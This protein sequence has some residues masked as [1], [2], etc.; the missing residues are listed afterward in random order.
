MARFSPA[1]AN[2]HLMSRE[3]TQ[4][5]LGASIGGESMMPAPHDFEHRVRYLARFMDHPMMIRMYPS[6]AL[7]RAAAEQ[8]W[9]KAKL[10][11]LISVTTS[12]GEALLFGD[13]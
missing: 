8:R 7:R 13:L 3:L 11:S 10:E 9:A 1:G 4:G 12:E 5:A 2:P 6:P